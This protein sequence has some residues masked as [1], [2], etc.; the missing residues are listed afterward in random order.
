MKKRESVMKKPIYIIILLVITLL[1]CQAK[2]IYAYE[3][4][5]TLKT[6]YNIQHFRNIYHRN[7]SREKVEPTTI[8]LPNAEIAHFIPVKLQ[9]TKFKQLKNLL[10]KLGEV[11]ITINKNGIK[12]A[13]VLLDIYEDLLSNHPFI[14]LVEYVDINGNHYKNVKKKSF[15]KMWEAAGKEAYVYQT[16]VDINF[17]E[18]VDKATKAYIIG[19]YIKNFE[20][21]SVEN[22]EFKDSNSVTL[23]FNIGTPGSVK[24]NSFL[25][26]LFSMQGEKGYRIVSIKPSDGGG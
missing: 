8:L 21:A 13:V 12:Q 16:V 11:T 22:V 14:E 4:L 19:Y 6:P 3:N 23:T 1:F 24:S 18:N 5:Y 25:S 2:K 10:Q 15:V 17:Q 7:Y 9:L 20:G 26:K